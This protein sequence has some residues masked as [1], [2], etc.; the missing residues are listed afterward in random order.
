MSQRAFIVLIILLAVL[1]ALSATPFPGAMIGFLFGIAV[2]FFI[3]GPAMLIGKQL[4]QAGMPVS[5]TATLWVLG[6]LYALLLL[7]AAFRIWRRLRQQDPDQAR[8]A[9]MRLALLIALPCIAWLSV[10]AMQDAWP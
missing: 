10:N 8:S 9:G 3:A 4:E 1:V 6:G 5:G 2:A 7:A